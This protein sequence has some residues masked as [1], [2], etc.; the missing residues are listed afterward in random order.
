MLCA[1]ASH[2]DTQAHL[3]LSRRIREECFEMAVE[4][5]DLAERFQTP[6]FVL[7]RS[8]HRH[9]RL[10]GAEAR[11][12]TT[13]IVPIAARCSAPRSSSRLQELL[14]LS[15]RRRRRHRRTARCPAC[16]RRARISRAARATTSSA[17]TP[18]IGDE[19][20]E[21]VDRIDAQD[22]ERG[23]RRCRRRSSSARRPGAKLGLVTIGG[24][25]AALRR[26]ARPA[27][28]GRRRRR[29]HARARLPVRRRGARVPR[30]A[31]AST[32][33]SSRTATRSCAACCMLETGCR[34]SR[35]SSRCA[36]TAASR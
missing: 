15:R 14:P 13:A 32:S 1:Y 28:R 34:R 31:R 36:T 21:V 33:S 19:Y 20:M 7:S 2:G 4:A 25:H 35:S 16:T 5:F 11:R 17:A 22:P 8:R 29:L 18:R 26:G 10:D 30:S 9:E 12:G 6:V 23:A 27:R 24:C 3:P